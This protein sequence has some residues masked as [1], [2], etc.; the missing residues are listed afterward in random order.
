MKTTDGCE[1][2]IEYEVYKHSRLILN[3]VQ[4]LGEFKNVPI[5]N[6][7]SKILKLIISY[8]KV[9]MNPGREDWSDAFFEENLKDLPE[10]LKAVLYLEFDEVSSN[11]SMFIARKIRMCDNIDEIKSTLICK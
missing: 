8:V 10:L 5:P 1:M 6:L 9:M 11:L 4:D 2:I 7:D 3:C